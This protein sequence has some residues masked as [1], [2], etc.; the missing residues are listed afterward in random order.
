MEV[1]CWRILLINIAVV[2]LNLSSSMRGMYSLVVV[3]VLA[4]RLFMTVAVPIYDEKVIIHQ[5]YLNRLWI[6]ALLK[7]NVKIKLNRNG[8][9]RAKLSLS[10]RTTVT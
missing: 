10:Y 5:V 8:P 1:Q 9:I 6:S 7:L 2:K 4:N 3:M